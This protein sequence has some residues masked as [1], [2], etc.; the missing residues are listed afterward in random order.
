MI[1]LGHYH[2]FQQLGATAWHIGSIRWVNFNEAKD[3]EK[4]YAIL[5]TDAMKVEFYPIKSAIHMYDVTNI[6]EAK[7]LLEDKSK[8][9]LIID[10]FKCFKEHVNEIGQI[11]DLYGDA[12]KVKLDFKEVQEQNT[13][14]MA[15]DGRSFDDIFNEYILT[16]KDEEIKKLLKDTYENK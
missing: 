12:F 4:Y 1:F 9:R 6:E 16:I 13:I 15:K 11:K 7:V 10:S 2:S 8:V 3:K 5:D 14:Q